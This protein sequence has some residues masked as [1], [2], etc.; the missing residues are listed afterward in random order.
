MAGGGAGL[1]GSGIV[2]AYHKRWIVSL[3]AQTLPLYNMVPG[4]H[5]TETVMSSEEIKETE[6]RQ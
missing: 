6:I 1:T 2:A 3:M 5:F 4:V